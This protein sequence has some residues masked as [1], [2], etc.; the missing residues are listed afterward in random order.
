MVKFTYTD[1]TSRG[2]HRGMR[3]AVRLAAW[4]PAMRAAPRTSPLVMALLA[5]LDVVSGSMVTLQRASARRW[6]GSLGV[7]ST[8]RALPSGSTWVR[9]R[10]VMWASLDSSGA[11]GRLT[12]QFE[13]RRWSAAD[14]AHAPRGPHE[15]HLTDV[16]AG[17]LRA[18]GALDGGGQVVVGGTIS[19]NRPEV[20]LVQREQT[21]AELS[22][23]GDPHPVTIAAERP[24]H[25][26]D[27]PDL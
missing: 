1:P 20:V 22:L 7:T 25:G 26:G 17:P 11:P 15:A 12:S 23:G 6:L 5:T 19:H 9:P 3:S 10:S 2:W 13:C 8:M 24:R 14:L 18:H 16:M 21:G 4:I 27:D